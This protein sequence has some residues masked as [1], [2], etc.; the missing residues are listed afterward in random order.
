[1][2]SNREATANAD[3]SSKTSPNALNIGSRSSFINRTQSILE[4]ASKGFT[5][6]DILSTARR[7]GIKVMNI[8]EIERHIEKY[9]NKTRKNS[10]ETTAKTKTELIRQSSFQ[11][12][13]LS[14]NQKSKN[15]FS[16]C[17]FSGHG[18][19]KRAYYSVNACK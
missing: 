17:S 15:Y 18:H 14:T 19:L 4:K 12:S 3:S 16:H 11:L 10:E 7:L 2:I 13:K 8:A 9:L 6:S 1:V 5:T